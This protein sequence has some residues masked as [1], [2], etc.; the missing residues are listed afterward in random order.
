MPELGAP[1]STPDKYGLTLL[2]TARE[3]GFIAS[4]ELPEERGAKTRVDLIIEM[5]GQ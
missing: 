3:K 2:D 5:S 4:T 1:C